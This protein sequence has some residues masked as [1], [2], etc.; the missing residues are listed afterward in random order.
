MII[1]NKDAAPVPPIRKNGSRRTFNLINRNSL[2]TVLVLG[3]FAAILAGKILTAPKESESEQ[4]I[5][6]SNFE[7]RL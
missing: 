3:T 5:D 6:E 7:S 1:V 4:W 2:T